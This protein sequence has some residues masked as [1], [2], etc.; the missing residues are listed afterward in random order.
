MGAWWRRE[1]RREKPPPRVDSTEEEEANRQAHTFSYACIDYSRAID[2]IRL[3][4]HHVH[5]RL[6]VRH[7]PCPW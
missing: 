3:R 2:V 5:A 4:L 6:E 7:P 1:H